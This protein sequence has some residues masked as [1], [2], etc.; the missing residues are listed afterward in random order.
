MDN[1]RQ[2]RSK[3]DTLYVGSSL[4]LIN[5][6]DYFVIRNWLNYAKIIGDNSYEEIFNKK[7][8]FNFLNNIL[9]K[10]YDF[11]KQQL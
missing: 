3:E 8:E 1:E 7:I 6:S 11:R 2:K 10:Q 4:N 5:L 9:K